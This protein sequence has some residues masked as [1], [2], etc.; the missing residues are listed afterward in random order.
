VV[1]V[2]ERRERRLAG[3]IGLF[4]VLVAT[5]G[6]LLGDALHAAPRTAVQLGLLWLAGACDVVAALRSPLTDRVPWYRWSGVANV[7]LGLSLPLGFLGPGED[8]LLAALVGLGGLSLAAL[9]VDLALF[10]GRHT[11]GEAVDRD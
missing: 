5:G 2:N 7:L 9:G 1:T 10:R 3:G 8:P 4:L 6:F 11:R